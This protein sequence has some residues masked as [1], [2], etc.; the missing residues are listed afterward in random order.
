[1]RNGERE[2]TSKRRQQRTRKARGESEH[3]RRHR[4]RLRQLPLVCVLLPR[5]CVVHDLRQ[6]RGRRKIQAH[7]R[8]RTQSHSHTNTRAQGADNRQKKNRSAFVRQPAGRE[9]REIRSKAKESVVAPPRVWNGQHNTR[10]FSFGGGAKG[11]EEGREGGGCGRTRGMGKGMEEE[12]GAFLFVFLGVARGVEKER[13]EKLKSEESKKPRKH[14]SGRGQ[15]RGG[16]GATEKTVQGQRKRGRMKSCTTRGS[17]QQRVRSQHTSPRTHAY[18][19]RRGQK[20]YG[21]LRERSSNTG[22]TGTRNCGK[23]AARPFCCGWCRVRANVSA[24][25][26]LDDRRPEQRRR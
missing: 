25:A 3:R 22:K 18:C 5:V 9:G 24:S 21:K 16:G 2:A 4:H 13:K 26:P 12:H 17:G 19:Q 23:Q 7:R 1:M 15:R 8:T 10:H 14:T 20:K 6:E 11:D